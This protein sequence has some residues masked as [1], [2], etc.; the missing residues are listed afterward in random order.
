VAAACACKGDVVIDGK[1]TTWIVRSIIPEVILPLETNIRAQLRERE[2]RPRSR[3]DAAE[4]FD[5]ESPIQHCAF[6]GESWVQTDVKYFFT[7]NTP[8]EILQF[9]EMYAYPNVNITARNYCG[10]AVPPQLT[11]IKLA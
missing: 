5:A 3:L 10:R 8:L 4:K 6:I 9:I 1:A 11:K 7:T 2:P